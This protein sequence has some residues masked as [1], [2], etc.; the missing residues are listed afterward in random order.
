[1]TN[2]LPDENY[3][4]VENGGMELQ[5]H[6]SKRINRDFS[7]NISGNF[8]YARNKIIEQD[9]TPWGAGHEYM[10]S[11]G[12]P[13][14]SGLYYQVIGV[15]KTEAD[16]QRYPQVSGATLGDF[17]YADLDGD[18]A[19]TNLDRKRS[20]YTTVPQIAFGAT[21]QV[22]YKGFDL[23][24]LLQGQARARYY[25]SPLV[26]PL[27]SNFDKRAA[28]RAWTLDNR[29]SNYPRLGS[30]ISNGGVYN[31]SF[32]HYDASFIRLK[33]VEIGYNLPKTWLQQAG[34]SDCRIYVGGYNLLTFDNLKT[35][36]PETSD[37]ENQNYP[38]LR[39][40]NAGIKLTF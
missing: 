32:Y 34:I 23:M 15:N 37:T 1:M 29:D 6:H 3:G 33:N 27:S 17:I 13:M 7:Y 8:V 21:V 25:Y 5:L 24:V 39:V 35:V 12:L 11:T 30:T 28:E 40:F 22:R 10:N 16:L 38:Q 14:G 26:D 4:I 31:S 20:E 18:G 19:I 9:E 2:N 36:D